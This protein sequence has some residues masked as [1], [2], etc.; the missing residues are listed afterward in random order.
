MRRQEVP[1]AQRSKDP[2]STQRRPLVPKLNLSGLST[3]GSS[4]TALR[5]ASRASGRHAPTPR[6]GHQDAIDAGRH[7][8]RALLATVPVELAAEAAADVARA[9]GGSVQDQV[10]AAALV[11]GDG[12]G[13][14]SQAY[15]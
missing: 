7:G 12:G 9:S 15:P 8:G 14:P 5:P 11:V 1:P 10:F 13:T 2:G 4:D 6:D 3:L